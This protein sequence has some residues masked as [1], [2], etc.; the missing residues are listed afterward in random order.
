[1]EARRL[2]ASRHDRP[3]R[4]HSYARWFLATLG[5]QFMARD[6]ARAAAALTFTTLI[7]AVPF[8]A[9]IYR[10]PVAA[11]PCSTTPAT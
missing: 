6:C 4:S 9:V 7:A 10:V 11:C 1:M 8:I 3:P 5:R 2:V